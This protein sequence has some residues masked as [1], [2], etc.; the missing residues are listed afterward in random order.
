M[1][2]GPIDFHFFEENKLGPESTRHKL[3][4]FFM[5]AALLIEELVAGEGE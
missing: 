1:S 2:I 3:Q 4:D 5:G